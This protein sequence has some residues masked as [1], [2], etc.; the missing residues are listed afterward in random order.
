[1]RAKKLYQQ[2]KPGTAFCTAFDEEKIPIFTMEDLRELDFTISRGIS[3]ERTVDEFLTQMAV[4]YS[5]RNMV[6]RKEIAILLNE[7]G[8]LV[9]EAGEWLLYFTPN[10]NEEHTLHSESALYP[11]LK[12][13]EEK[14]KNGEVCRVKVP[15]R[16]LKTLVSGAAPF[17]ILDEYCKHQPG[18]YLSVAENIVINGTD[19]LFRNVPVCSYNKL[20]TVD[21][22]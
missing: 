9:R 6:N 20:Q 12:S 2:Y 11:V 19:E 14:Y 13:I 18:R 5:F 10:K 8:A 21:K 1:M 22:D 15:D 4:N 16:T 17:S 3:Y 7:E